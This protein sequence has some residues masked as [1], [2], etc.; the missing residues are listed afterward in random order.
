MQGKQRFTNA[1]IVTPNSLQDKDLLLDKG[2]IVDIIDKEKSTSNDWQIVNANNNYIFPG[3]IDVL[4]HGF[5]NHLY[6]DIE[7]NCIV[8]NSKYLP[9]FG[10]TGYLPSISCL[11]PDKTAQILTSL[12]EECDL[13]KDGSRVL[14]IHSEGPCFV[15]PGAHNPKN[16]LKKTIERLVEHFLL[17]SSNISNVPIIS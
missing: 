9:A 17:Y 2:S 5:L 10:V 14:G 15:L 1:T 6:I 4:Q 16:L 12:S 3:M 7:K 11:P 8:N 13:S